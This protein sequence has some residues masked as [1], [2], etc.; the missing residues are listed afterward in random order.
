MERNSRNQMKEEQERAFQEAQ[1]RDQ[2]REFAIK[3]QE[4]EIRMQEQVME[5]KRIS[6]LEAKEAADAKAAV[7]QSEA[8]STLP[9][10]PPA[11]CGKVLAN[12]RFR[13]PSSTLARRFLGS[14][15]LSVLFLYLRSEGFRPE[16]YKVLS[17]WPRRDLTK[18]D[19]TATLEALK[20]CPQETLTLEAINHGDSDSE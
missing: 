14:N 8:A 1:I 19:P 7:E 12:I 2:E 16:D 3:E 11:D 5:A 9:G 6:E 18:L 15:P 4:E 17:A 13:T 20:L 10:E